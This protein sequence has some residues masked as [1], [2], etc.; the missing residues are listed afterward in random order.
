M[1]PYD[2]QYLSFSQSPEGAFDNRYSTKQANRK[3][4]PKNTYKLIQYKSSN[5]FVKHNYKRRIFCEPCVTWKLNP[6]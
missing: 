3:K 4:N 5:E 1:L 2:K 6:C